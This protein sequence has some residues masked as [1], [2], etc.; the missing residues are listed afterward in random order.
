MGL[1]KAHLLTIVEL[2]LRKVQQSSNRFQLSS[3]SSTKVSKAQQHSEMV[4]FGTG[5]T[6]I[7]QAVLLHWNGK[8]LH[9]VIQVIRLT[10]A[11]F[12]VATFH[13]LDLSRAAV[14]AQLDSLVQFPTTKV[15]ITVLAN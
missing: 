1:K 14:S 11:G 2:W 6:I 8:L 7:V 13:G 10:Q 12:E 5:Y 9:A 3:T 4:N 15:V